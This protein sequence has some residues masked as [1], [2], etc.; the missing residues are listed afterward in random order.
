MGT[1]YVLKPV[2]QARNGVFVTY[3]KLEM[4]TEIKTTGIIGQRYN[5]GAT[6]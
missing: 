5:V 6:T 1:F 2:I 3:G 4:T